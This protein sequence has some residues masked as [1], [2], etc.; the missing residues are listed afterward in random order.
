MYFSTENDNNFELGIMIG[1]I[2]RGDH[3]GSPHSPYKSTTQVLGLTVALS[4]L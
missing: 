2:Y 3:L 4:Q 1:H